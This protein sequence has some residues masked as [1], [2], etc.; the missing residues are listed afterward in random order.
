[1][2]IWSQGYYTAVVKGEDSDYNL[3]SL[4]EFLI[5]DSMTNFFIEIIK[6]TADKKVSTYSIINRIRDITSPAYFIKFSVKNKEYWSGYHSALS[7]INKQEANNVIT[8]NKEWFEFYKSTI[9]KSIDGFTA[10][11]KRELRNK[12]TTD[13]RRLECEKSIVVLQSVKDKLNTTTFIDFM[14]R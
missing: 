6:N 5:S 12:N 13:N 8:I 9:I 2:S 7:D 11:F 1:M 14:T 3:N 4:T 10:R